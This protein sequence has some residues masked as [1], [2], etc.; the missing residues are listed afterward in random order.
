VG[1]LGRV[2]FKL[3]LKWRL[4]VRK[5]TGLDGKLKKGK[6]NKGAAAEGGDDDDDDDDE[7]EAKVVRCSFT[8]GR[9][10]STPRLLSTFETKI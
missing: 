1:V 4:T 10:Q 7:D 9:K 3:L 5:S 6:S 2:D 8:P